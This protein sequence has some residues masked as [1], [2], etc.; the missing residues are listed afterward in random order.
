MQV[1]FLLLFRAVENIVISDWSTDRIQICSKE[2]NL[3]KM[4]GERRHQAGMLCYP[5][6]LA[7][8]KQLSLVVVSL[9]KTFFSNI[10]L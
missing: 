9:N 6:G 5:R 3:I 7:L 8:T 2:G 1:T 4:I 10:F